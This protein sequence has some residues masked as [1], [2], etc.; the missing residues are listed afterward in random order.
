VIPRTRGTA[1]RTALGVAGLLLLLAGSWPAATAHAVASRL[2]SWWP[3]AREG[4]GLLDREQLARWRGAD[5]W[6]PT[7]LAVAI[8]LT[9]LFACWFLTLL[10]LGRARPLA[11]PCPG[12]TVRP[13]ALAEALT[14]RVA[15]LPGVARSRARVL[16]R[17]GQRLEFGL[18]VWLEP[19]T[20][21]DAVLPGLRA[22]T[23]EAERTVAPYA[24]CARIRLSAASHRMPHVR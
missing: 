15:A 4:T 14:A 16:S 1:N 18:R 21:P 6:T 7:V 11:L 23:A 2:P 9:V 24:L 8:G 3:A 22:V 12:G 5:W 10:R 19:D 20:P 17:P 13:Q